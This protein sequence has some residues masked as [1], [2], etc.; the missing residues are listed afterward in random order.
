MKR[1][2]RLLL[3][4]V[5]CCLNL[6]LSAQNPY[7]TKKIPP[8]QLQEDFQQYKTVLQI[9]HPS[10]YW[11]T[12]EATMQAA[13]DQVE[14]QLT[15]A[16]TEQEFYSLLAP[17]TA[18]INCG[19]TGTM[20]S[21]EARLSFKGRIPLEFFYKAGKLYLFYDYQTQEYPMKEVQSINGK[22]VETL[23]NQL[24]RLNGTDG[25]IETPKSLFFN[26]SG[27]FGY[28]YSL[29]YPDSTYEVSLKN[30]KT[31]RREAIAS[32]SLAKIS[33]PFYPTQDF[34]S[35]EIRQED[36]VAILT[37]NTFDKG[38]LKN[39]EWKYKKYIKDFFKEIK[40]EDIQSLII[41]LSRNGG[42]E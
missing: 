32:D 17:L 26:N 12:D 6:A 5:F 10:L 38:A 1:S 28:R 18:L 14:S 9:I 11:Y 37:I 30:G 23:Y 25:F 35:Y 40:E 29:L 7:Y 16:K 20:P 39:A 3:L 36:K 19:H 21:Y 34:L 4:L 33:K 31:L 2:T 22:T 8:A 24:S 41:D 13:Y 27:A 42:G 15:T